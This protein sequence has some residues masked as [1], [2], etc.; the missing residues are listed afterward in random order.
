MFKR[1][2]VCETPFPPNDVLERFPT[3]ER[4][5]FDSA[6]GRLWAVC[7]ACRGWSL[8]PI[9]ERW[10]A[11][12]ELEKLV[13]D[14]GRLLSQSDN[15]ALI[16]AGP[17]EVVRVGRAGLTEEAWWRYGRE[18]TSRR[19]T[20]RKLS[21][22]GAVGMG[23]LL[24]GGWATGGVG[25]IGGYW[26]WGNGSRVVTRSA[27]WMRFGGAAWRGTGSCAACGYEFRQVRY[28]ERHGLYLV[29]GSDDESAAE[30]VYRCPECAH[31]REGGLHLTGREGERVLRR[32]LAYSHFKGASEREV[33]SATR[34]IEEAGSAKALARIVIRDGRRLGDL[35]RTGALGLEIAANEHA[36]QRLLEL[37]LAELEASWAQEEELAA[38]VDGELTPLP[39]LEQMRLK[40]TG[41]A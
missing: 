7:R 12:E 39:L 17:L 2:L 27:R 18:L 23:A 38:I 1:C 9:E 6:R 24:L 3:G 11:I 14:R 40:V 32:V 25:V 20:Y 26:L 37:E 36:E 5:A 22:A 28:R 29:P 21:V 41:R 4:V 13:T 33:R 34:L 10:E 30:I 35:Q 15:I 16:R 8:A 19:E 31:H